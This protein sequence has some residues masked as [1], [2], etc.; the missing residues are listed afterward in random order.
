MLLLIDNYDSFAHNL[1]RYLTRLGC[2][3]QVVRNDAVTVQQVRQLQPQ[4]IVLSPGPCTPQ[5]AGCTLD[6]VRQF[7]RHLPLLGICLGHQTIVAALGGRIGALRAPARAGQRYSPRW[8]GCLCR[9]AESA[10]RVPLS[11]AGG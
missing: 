1:A 7:H 10:A 11:L 4:A 6:L 8:N 3:L 2:Q 9:R 5:E